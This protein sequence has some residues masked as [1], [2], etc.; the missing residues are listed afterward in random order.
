MNAER[1]SRSLRR[2]SQKKCTRR[3]A[4]IIQHDFY[5]QGAALLGRNRGQRVKH[6]EGLLESQCRWRLIDGRIP[7]SA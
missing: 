1:R 2:R 6:G 3:R 4:A 7:P 5:L